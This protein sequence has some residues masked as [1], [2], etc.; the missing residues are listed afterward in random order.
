MFYKLKYHTIFRKFDNIGY[1][2]YQ[3]IPLDIDRVVD[4]IGAIF[5]SNLDYSPISVKN[6]S[7]KIIN[8]FSGTTVQE[9]ECDLQTFFDTL[10]MEGFLHSGKTYD[11][12]LKQKDDFDY[13]KSQIEALK[14]LPGNKSDNRYGT[15][16]YLENFFAQNPKMQKCQIEIT[17]RCNERC[18]HCYIP[19]QTK[20]HGPLLIFQKCLRRNTRYPFRIIST[21]CESTRRK[22]C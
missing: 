9:I 5:L 8:L 20:I 15:Q 13:S 18:I 21:W 10:V 2:I 17:S 11:E 16:E 6:I 19:H 22:R 1:L 4:E 3:Q 12:C 7:E 14:S